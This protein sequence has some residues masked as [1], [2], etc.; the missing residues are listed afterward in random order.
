MS[1]VQRYTGL[2]SGSFCSD[3][4][5]SPAARLAVTEKASLTPRERVVEVGVFGEGGMEEDFIR[6]APGILSPAPE[7][8]PAVEKG[9]VFSPASEARM[10]TVL[11][12]WSPMFYGSGFTASPYSILLSESLIS[13]PTLSSDFFTQIWKL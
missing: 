3:G 2:S 6:T 1:V 9:M 8:L 5:I 12:D 7:A 4:T 11:N 13:S 10:M